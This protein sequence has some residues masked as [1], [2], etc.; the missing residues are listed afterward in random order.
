MCWLRRTDLLPMQYALQGEMVNQGDGKPVRSRLKAV[1]V[2]ACVSVL[3]VP[4]LEPVSTYLP[5]DV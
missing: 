1:E 4:L 2:R 3:S 5:A